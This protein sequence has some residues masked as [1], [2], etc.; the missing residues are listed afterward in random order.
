MKKLFYLFTI[1]TIA[2]ACVY[3]KP[4]KAEIRFVND[5]VVK[6]KAV[7]KLVIFEF[8]APECGPCIRLKHDIFDNEK[9]NEFLNKNFLIVKVSPSDSVYKQL[10][11][12]F[13]LKF[14]SSVIFLDQNGNEIDRTVSYDGN[15]VAYYNFLK[16]VSEG[17]NLYSVIFSIY[18]KDTLNVNSNYML[19]RKLLFRYQVKDAVRHFNKVLL[20]DPQNKY[21]HNEECKFKI[22]ESDL[23]L[24]GNM[25]G[26]MDFVRTDLKND[27]VPKAYEYLID[28]LIKR[29]NRDSCLSLCEEALIKYPGSYEILNKY[30][31]AIFSFELRNDY[32]KALLMAQK[33]ISINP[34]RSGT[35]ATEAWI[36]FRL[37]ENQKAIDLLNK[38]IELYPHP[39]YIKD[40][41]VFKSDPVNRKF[42]N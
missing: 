23:L 12:Y 17:R 4:E 28:D 6:A 14:Q 24:D 22:A 5:A 25:H 33:S 16:E 32:P 3:R 31:W 15:R 40:L 30:A 8:W 29:K 34:E 9:Y 2:F 18:E 20:Y 7:N 19:A 42:P 1:L 27:Y 35:Y 21:G 41:A 38:A 39:S 37:G 36:E 13:N 10:W 11:Q 26:I